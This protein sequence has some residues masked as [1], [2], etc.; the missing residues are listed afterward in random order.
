MC[1]AYRREFATPRIGRI[2][3]SAIGYSDRPRRPLK[4][5]IE[6]TYAWFMEHLAEAR[7]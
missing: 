1:Q 7:L 4:G 5:G 2:G 6:R 3:V